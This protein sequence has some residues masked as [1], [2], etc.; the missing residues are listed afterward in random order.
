MRAIIIAAG[1]GR[2]LRPYTDERPKCMVQLR[3]KSLLEHQIDAL[4]SAGVDDIVVVRGYLRRAINLPG[5]TYV[6]NPRFKEN[7]ILESLFCAR[8]HLWGDLIISYGDIIYHPALIPE[9]LKQNAPAALVCDQA[10]QDT[11]QG[12]SDHPE[13]EAELCKISVFSQ[14][15]LPNVSLFRVLEVGKHVE[16]PEGVAEFI[17]LAKFS[18]AVVARLVACYDVALQRGREV[19]YQQAPRLREAY[20]SDLLNDAIQQELFIQPFLIKGS[21]R[22]IDTVQDLERAEQEISW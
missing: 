18:A 9:L 3:G 5:I 19:P 22:E 2:R 8:E 15:D 10:W 12:R 6:D 14:F 1:Q 7:N 17:G 16:P 20:L 21:W 13:S 11:Y 4:R